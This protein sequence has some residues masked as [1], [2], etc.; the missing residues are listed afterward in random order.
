[1]YKINNMGLN[2]AIDYCMNVKIL[3]KEEY[4]NKHC[5]IFGHSVI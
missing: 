2:Q 3:R 5:S 1:M 4:K